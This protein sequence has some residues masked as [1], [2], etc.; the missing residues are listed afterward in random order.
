MAFTCERT[1]PHGPTPCTAPSPKRLQP[2]AD[3]PPR[4]GTIWCAARAISF[5]ARSD[6]GIADLTRR[7]VR[8]DVEP[9]TGAGRVPLC[10]ALRTTS[11]ALAYECQ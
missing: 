4:S 6:T 2:I 10:L 9:P 5:L 1:A 7:M 8:F 3:E 11:L